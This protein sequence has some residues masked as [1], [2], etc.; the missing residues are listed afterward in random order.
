MIF[1]PLLKLVIQFRFC[2]LPA[3]KIQSMDL[4][5]IHSIFD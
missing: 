5:I 3:L 2:L 4:L 1:L